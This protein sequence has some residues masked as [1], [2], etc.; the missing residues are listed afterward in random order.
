MLFLMYSYLFVVFLGLLV[1]VSGSD[2]II[3]SYFNLFHSLNGEFSLRSRIQLITGKDGHNQFVFLDNNKI[4]QV[5]LS[6]FK[7]LLDSN[8]FYQIKIQSV[9]GNYTSPMVLSSIPAVR[10]FLVFISLKQS[11]LL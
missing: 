9:T 4:S 7:D 8:S 11:F 1:T 6:F 10:S 2:E 5:E 3:E